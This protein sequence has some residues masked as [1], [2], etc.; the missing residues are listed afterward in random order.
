MGIEDN[1]V[2]SFPEVLGR[3]NFLDDVYHLEYAMGIEDNVV[4]S[5]P[6]GLGR[7]NFLD[8]VYSLQFFP[9]LKNVSKCKYHL[10][11]GIIYLCYRYF[12]Q[13]SK[14]GDSLRR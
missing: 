1:V 3:F 12:P 10:Y 11:A 2:T 8:D 9:Q 14:G 7:F 4:T 5:F 6:E 13:P